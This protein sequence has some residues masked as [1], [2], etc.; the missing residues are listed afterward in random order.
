[1]QA[2]LC[3]SCPFHYRLKANTRR[4]NVSGFSAEDGGCF[5]CALQRSPCCRC[6]QVAAGKAPASMGP[7]SSPARR[8]QSHG[9]TTSPLPHRLPC[10][11]SCL[12]D[13][14]PP[15]AWR[16][17]WTS[18]SAQGA[19]GRAARRAR[20]PCHSHQWHGEVWGPLYVICL[21]E[22]RLG[23]IKAIISQPTR[24]GFFFFF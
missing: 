24:R 11:P 19:G 4:A 18:C 23:L 2:T 7:G 10:H 13:V 12:T 15:G 5:P 8:S 22:T 17:G 14:S 6:V 1:M 9:S 20:P 21:T 3:P 16:G